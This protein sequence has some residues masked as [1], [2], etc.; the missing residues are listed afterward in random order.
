MTATWYTEEVQKALGWPSDCTPI[1]NEIVNSSRI[2]TNR[3]KYLSSYL[4]NE[5]IRLDH[6]SIKI[7][8]GLRAAAKIFLNAF[9]GK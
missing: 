1:G 6:N 3:K 4:K 2:Q 8:I 7:N 5:G 9:Y